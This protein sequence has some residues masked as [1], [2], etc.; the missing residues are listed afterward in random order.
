MQRNGGKLSPKSPDNLEIVQ[1]GRGINSEIFGV[2]LVY[3]VDEIAYKTK[4][5][6][7]TVNFLMA[8]A[9]PAIMSVLYK[10][11]QENSLSQAGLQNYLQIIGI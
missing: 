3:T 10:I 1:K 6:N 8:S 9:T 11:A 5:R 2:N 7:K 4:A